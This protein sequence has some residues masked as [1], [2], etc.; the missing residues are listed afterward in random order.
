MV[1]IRQMRMVSYLAVLLMIAMYIAPAAGIAKS[2]P[3]A[4]PIQARTVLVF[5]FEN[6]AKSSVETLSEDLLESVQTSL[7]TSGALRAMA[8]SDKLPSIQRSVRELTLKADDIKGPF[9]TDKDQIT[10]AL[11]VGR[12]IASDLVLIGT[13]DDIQA[14]ATGKKAE[15]TLTAVLAD[16]RTGEP[17]KTVA[18]TG[19]APAN[20]TSTIEADLIAQAAGDAVAKMTRELVP[21]GQ[22]VATPATTQ[23]N[24]PVV[25]KKSKKKTSMLR[26]LLIP[27]V[28]GVAAAL[29]SSS[30]DDNDG[31]EEMDNPPPSPF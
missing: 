18:V 4:A 11:K 22:A 17:V 5:P 15:I 21:A 28:I 24:T 27:L 9:G 1:R 31:G 2:A 29:I 13:I 16:V 3:K 25:V 6:T 8:F 26:K 23:G 7:S 19:Q 20:T 12:E 30:G 14:D 10:S